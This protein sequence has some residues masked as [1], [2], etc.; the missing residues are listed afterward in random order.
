MQPQPAQVGSD[1]DGNPLRL[2]GKRVEQQR[3]RWVVEDGW[4]TPRPVRRRYFELVLEDG[5]NAV[6][7]QDLG[8]RRWYL[9]AA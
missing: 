1:K 8:S 2:R 7:F 3:E 9:Q 6:V 4:W 5:A